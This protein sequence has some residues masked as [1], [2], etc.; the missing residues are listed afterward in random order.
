MRAE[1]KSALQSAHSDL[2]RDMNPTALKEPLYTRKLLTTDE[3][4]MLDIKPTT[5][6][7]NTFIA[8]LLPRKGASAFRDF[9]TCLRETGDENGAHID[10]A[11]DLESRLHDE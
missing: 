6:G 2:I 5:R 4:E 3:Y 11:N 9:I 8:M 7:K 10:L 1:E